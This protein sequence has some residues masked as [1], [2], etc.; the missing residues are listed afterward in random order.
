MKLLLLSLI[1]ST[2]MALSLPSDEF[3]LLIVFLRN[4]NIS[5]CRL[6]GFDSQFLIMLISPGPDQPEGEPVEYLYEGDDAEPHEEPEETPDLGYEVQQGHPGLKLGGS[7][8]THN[9][10]S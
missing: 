1:T 2:L 5:D 8:R 6:N 4:S 7:V 9:F 3:S 10:D